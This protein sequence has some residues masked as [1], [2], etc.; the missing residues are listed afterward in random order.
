[1][2]FKD[3]IELMQSSEKYVF[4][5][6]TYLKCSRSFLKSAAYL[7]FCSCSPFIRERFP[8]SVNADKR[9]RPTTAGVKIK[10]RHK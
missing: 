9:G 3:L 5:Y 7:L 10:V 2:L 4:L 6:K 1:M 8:E